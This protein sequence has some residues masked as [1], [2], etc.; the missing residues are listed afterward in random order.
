MCKILRCFLYV[1]AEI[2]IINFFLYIEEICSVMNLYSDCIRMIRSNVQREA[3]IGGLQPEVI[4]CYS[5][6]EALIEVHS[7]LLLFIRR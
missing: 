2:V 7:L 6:K 3:L 1:P 4:D 5:T